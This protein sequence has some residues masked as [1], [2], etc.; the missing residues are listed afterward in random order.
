VTATATGTPPRTR[1]RFDWL[2]IGLPALIA[3]VPLLLTQPGIVGADTKTYLY[4]DPGKLLSEAPYLWNTDVGLGSVTHQN[5]G[6]L[7]PMGPFYLFFE[8]IGV[9]DW[10]AQRLWMGTLIFAAGMGVRFLLRTIGWGSIPLRRGGVLVATLAYMLSPYLLNYSARISVILL[11]WTALPWLIAFTARALRR[12]G[13]RDPALFALVVLTVG[14]VNATA[15]LLI[16]LGPLLWLVHAVVVDREAKARAALA[17]A[18]RIGV[19]TIAASL[20]WIAGLW[21]QGRYGLPVVRYT[22]TYEVIADASSAPEVLRGLGYWLFYG[23]DKLGPW[24][25][26]SITYTRNLF[27]L[28]LSYLVPLLAML[29]ASLLRWRYRAF[30]L[31]LVVVGTLAAVAGHPWDGSSFLGSL[32][33]DFTRTDAG[34]SLRSTPRAVPL[35]ALGLSVCLGA[36]VAALSR[37]VPRLTVPVTAV[38]VLLVAANL[39]TLWNGEM[40]AANLQRPEN[41][42]SYW[43]D[44]AKY[45]TETDDGTRVLEVPG[46]DFA[47][48]RWGN[49]IDPVT[50]GLTEREYAARELFLYG[51]EQAADLQL[52]VDQR[53]QENTLEPEAIAPLARLVGG[54]QIL[55]RNDLKY[56][57]YRLARPRYMWDLLRR[58]PGLTEPVTFGPSTPNR[59]G[60]ELPVI[61]EIELDAPD[62]WEDPPAI[63]VFGV[64]DPLATIR[65]SPSERPLLLSGSG[66]GLVDLAGVG[67][68]HPEQ[69]IFYSGTFAGDAGTIDE[70]VADG[71][72][73]VV[74]DT[75]RKRARSWNTLRENAGYTEQ[76]GEE[77]LTY[78]PGDQRLPLFPDADD[79]AYTVTEQEGNA[80]VLATGYGNIGTLTANDRAAGALDG[81]PLT[82]WRVA[83]GG[84]PK[85]ERLVIVADEPVTT[86]EV[87]LLQPINGVRT[88][89]I[90]QARLWFDGADPV[91]V[92]LGDASLAEPGQVVTFPERTFSRLEVEILA[93]TSGRRSLYFGQAGVGFAE[94]GVGD[95]RIR[96]LIR[97]PVDLLEA[98]GPASAANRLSY[99]FTRLRS[100]PSEPVRT[101][102]E[103]DMTRIVDVPTP[104]AFGLTAQARLN[105]LAPDQRLDALLQIPG[106]ADGGVSA[107]ASD[108]MPG[109]ISARA[110]AAVDG[111]PGTAWTTP[112]GALLGQWVEATGPTPLTIDRLD[113]RIVND[114]RHS[115]PTVVTLRADGDPALVRTI[116]LPTIDDQAD[117]DASVV[118][119]VSFEPLTGTTYRLTV[120][121]VR[122]VTT[123]DWYTKQPIDMPVGVAELG[124]PGLT[125]PAGPAAIDTGC[126]SDLLAVDGVPVPVRVTGTTAD[127]VRREPLTVETCD[128]QGAPIVLDAGRHELTTAIGRDVG[129]DLDRVVLASDRDG[130][131]LSSAG[132]QVP[133][134][135]ADVALDVTRD[136]GVGYEIEVPEA[137]EV[138][139]LS[140]GQSWSPGWT[141]EVAGRD[142]GPSVVI[143]GYANGWVLDPEVLGPGPYTVSVTWAPQRTIWIAIAVSALAILLCLGIILASLRRS[144]S[145]GRT[146]R[147]A[148][149]VEEDAEASLRT[150]HRALPL[151]PDL[152]PPPWALPQRPGVVEQASPRAALVAA[153][154]LFVVIVP[155]VPLTARELVIAPVVAALSWFAFRSP[156]GR[157]VLGL[158]GTASYALAVLYTMAAEW[159]RGE[160]ADFI[161]LVAPVNGLG[162]AAAFLLF[163]EGVRDVIVR[164]RRSEDRAPSSQET[165]P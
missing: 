8:T 95:L 3:Y 160:T 86:G 31:T 76:A 50:P 121:A 119:P 127:A 66:D 115:V 140:F 113:L 44:A 110:F 142:L 25:E 54:G 155:N 150:G 14:G 131:P 10:V 89:S 105:P 57:R 78:R 104:R 100:N 22:E 144:S 97:P 64:E 136:R 107:V 33:T 83:D 75:N 159:R 65:T 163:A 145:A 59:A 11:P 118:V 13:W 49:T 161:Q 165:A 67:A 41:I 38:V 46:A 138:R 72:D 116:E 92:D 70:M 141:A 45:L 158:A 106:A 85:G 18:A 101:D 132:L 47:S 73:L 147:D 108:S 32:F 84:D 35:I 43:V 96:E 154:A 164:R 149:P 60:P 90:T 74:T 146:S 23:T 137:D 51:S 12:G 124:I 55:L 153:V 135:E 156:R 109:A 30:F 24:I 20:W 34:L 102:T 162:L 15:L 112:F 152:S 123:T 120:D 88:R 63:A 99:V 128:P 52:A 62:T 58:A 82:A 36:G 114:G 53:Y 93:D 1:R 77:P 103:V 28:G 19:L 125:A 56:E 91:T 5:I 126:R 27:F 98:A 69:S 79:D 134:V 37:R 81:D 29:S 151:D 26:P 16:G 129:I 157:G 143:D 4:L 48:Y 40:V 122:P 68:L 61:D 42:P 148:D 133:V 94:V 2:G 39:P 87:R 80:T 130:G 139:W 111:D 17:A 71:A 9:P 117:P 7:W 21:A 6:Y